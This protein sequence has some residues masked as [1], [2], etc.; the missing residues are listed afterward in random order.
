MRQLIIA[1]ILASTALAQNTSKPSLDDQLT[2]V[3]RMLQAGRT[4]DA[5]R[6]LRQAVPKPEDEPAEPA[7]IFSAT[8]LHDILWALTGHYYLG[9][10]DYANANRVS[11][12]RLRAAEAKGAAGAGHLPIY[13]LLMAEVFR[14]QGKHAEAYPLYVRLNQLWIRNQL[15]A[16]FQ[17][18]TA[19]GYV[20]C[21]IVRGDASTAETVAR[22][23]VDTDGSETG[24][25]FHEDYFNTYA[26]AMDEAGHKAQA[27]QF[28]AKIDAGSRR[29]PAANQQDRDLFRARLANARGQDFAAE[30]IYQKWIAYWKTAKS[31]P[32][33]D[34]KE[35]LQIRMAALVGYSHFLA[36]RGRT[37][38]AQAIQAQL[39]AAGCRAGTCE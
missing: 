35:F 32:G 2:N 30:S 39:T 38:E 1:M 16:D 10:N 29:P 28:E 34:P 19:L 26:V 12:E 5:E 37:R 4:S 27:A 22:P 15:S 20:E 36:V 14:L 18:R 6:L 24:P 13:L 8:G 9:A 23:A 31:P 25:S 7:G 33:F 21:L 3:G 17:K 11:A